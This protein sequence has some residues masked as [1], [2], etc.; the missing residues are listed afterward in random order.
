MIWELRYDDI[1]WGH[2]EKHVSE[3]TNNSCHKSWLCIYNSMIQF[4]ILNSKRNISLLA[5]LMQNALDWSSKF[6]SNAYKF[7]PH[8]CMQP[9]DAHVCQWTELL[10]SSRVS[11][12]SGEM[13]IIAP[14]GG[15]F[16]NMV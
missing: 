15:P 6:G 9:G 5:N 10:L 1:V 3:N 4:K 11:E 7:M 8:N 14:T 16:T 12:R 2:D 13:I